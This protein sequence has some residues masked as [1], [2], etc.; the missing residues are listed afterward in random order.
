MAPPTA[1][2]SSK[3]ATRRRQFPSL[4]E[5]APASDNRVRLRPTPVCNAPLFARSMRR[6][7]NVHRPPSEK[8]M[9]RSRELVTEEN[10]RFVKLGAVL[11]CRQLWCASVHHA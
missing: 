2:I 10:N 7:Q 1:D 4:R 9:A 8:R 3:K 11:D 5:D 6:L